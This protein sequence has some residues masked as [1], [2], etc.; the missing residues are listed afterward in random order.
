[1]SW[2]LRRVMSF[3]FWLPLTMCGVCRSQDSA[4]RSLLVLQQE[5]E[6]GNPDAQARFGEKLMKGSGVKKD[7]ANGFQWSYR[8][9]LAGSPLGA[10][11]VASAY[12]AGSGVTQN[13]H[14]AFEWAWIAGLRGDGSSQGALAALYHS[15]EGVAKDLT[16]AYAWALVR[17]NAGDARITSFLTS[18]EDEITPDQRSEANALS[19]AW[20]VNKDHIMPLHSRWYFEHAATNERARSEPAPKAGPSTPCSSG[21]WVSSNIDDGK[22]IKL[23]DGSLWRV[24]DVDTVDSGLW[25]E[26]DDITVCSGKLINTDDKTSVGA[27]KIN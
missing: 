25:L 10:R 18:V 6:S 24:D 13:K 8:A 11:I 16:M 20:S 22:L 7:E 15:G 3:L 26:T 27:R 5:A 9:A 2:P 14:A 1:M 12:L 17:K 21:H 23:E 4:N 19:V